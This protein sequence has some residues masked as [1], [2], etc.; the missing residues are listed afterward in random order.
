MSDLNPF[1]TGYQWGDHNQ[2]IGEYTFPNNLDQ[3]AIHMPP[4]TTLV[5]VPSPIPSG[6]EPIWNGTVWTFETIQPL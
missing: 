2:F 1:I 6:T 4:R 5:R 3:D